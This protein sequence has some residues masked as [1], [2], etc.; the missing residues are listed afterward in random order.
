[1]AKSS[2]SDLTERAAEVTKRLAKV[3][4]DAHTALDFRNPLELL[5][6]TILS[7]QCTDVRVN[8]VTAELFKKYKKA[9]DYAS[10]DVPTFEQE[11]RP[12]GFYHNKARSV[13]GMAQRLLEHYG[14]QVPDNMDDLLTL[15]GVAR[16]TANVVLGSAFGKNEGV[17]VDTHVGRIATRLGLTKQ[18]DPVKIEKDLMALLPRKD[19]TRFAHLLIWH[20]RQACTA[21]KPDCAGCSLNDIC[22]SAFKAG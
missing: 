15:P 6:A 19:W 2:K 14:G 3:F 16:K 18:T 13:I 10:A 17:V 9:A 22:P 4:P 11:I 20:G 12:T 8:Q 5:V 7:A 21:R 1:L